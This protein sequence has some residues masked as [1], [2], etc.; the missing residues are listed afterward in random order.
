MTEAKDSRVYPGEVA[1]LGKRAG[2]RVS[3][4]PQLRLGSFGYLAHWPE[5]RA[6][7]SSLPTTARRAYP[8]RPKLSSL[9]FPAAGKQKI[10]KL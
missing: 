1:Q 2:S 10:A 3:T 6:K 4:D 5:V 9:Q 7:S 8:V